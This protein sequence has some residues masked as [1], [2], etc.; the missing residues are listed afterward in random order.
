MTMGPQGGITFPAL[1]YTSNTPHQ[2]GLR[3][4]PMDR[5]LGY[6]AGVHGTGYR[7]KATAVPLATGSAVHTG[8]EYL[9]QWVLDWQASHAGQRLTAIDDA[10]IAWAAREAAVGYER[11]AWARGVLLTATDATRAEAIEQ[12]ILEQRTLVEALIWIYGLVRLPLMLSQYRL[13]AVET[14]ETPVLACTCGLGDWVADDRTH[15]AR[16]CTGIVMQGRSDALWEAIDSGAIVYEEY[17]TKAMASYSWEQSWTHSGQLLINME[18]ASR[19][20]GRPVSEAFVVALYKGK[21]DRTDRKDVST[22]KTQ[23]SPLVYGWYDPGGLNRTPDW[24]ARYRWYDEYG[25]GHTLPRTYKRAPIWDPQF[26]LDPATNP[27]GVVLR[28]EAS[29]VEQWVKGWILPVQYA[30]L[31]KAFGPFPRQEARVPLAVQGVL[32]E[33]M[34]WRARVHHLRAQGA[35]EPGDALVDQI[36]P[37]SWNCTHFDGTPCQFVG[38]CQRDPGWEDLG[39]PEGAIGQLMQIRRPHHAPEA[40][41]FEAGGVVFPVDAGEEGE[42]GGE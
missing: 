32:A 34:T 18:A 31:I 3:D 23:Q 30:E 22:P 20:L 10:V 5:Y 1:W 35:V 39:D 14:E 25:G 2:V 13:L 19:R 37:R 7:R 41:A 26:P 40:Q 27:N 8:L 4:C 15:A 36:I 16:G 6:H 24:S 17:K 33:E 28:A 38:V 21:R 29:R 12:L 42:E 11:T 9:G